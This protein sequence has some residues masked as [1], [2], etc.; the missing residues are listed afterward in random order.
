MSLREQRHRLALPG[1]LTLAGGGTLPEVSVAFE[2]YGTLNAARDNAVLVLHGLTSDQ[3]AAGPAWHDGGKP[4]W[5]DRAIGPGRAIDTDRFYVISVNALGGAGG[6]T[7]P[8]S[9][10]PGTGRRYAMRFPVITIADMVQQQHRLMDA[11]GIGRLHATLG[12]CMGGFQVLEW[13]CLAPE[14]AGRAVIISATPRVS[15]HTIALWSVLRAALMSDPAWNGGEYYDGP[16]PDNGI[17]LLAA[18]GALFWMD[19]YTLAAKFGL[20]TVAGAPARPTLAPQF[21]VE[22]FLQDVRTSAAGKLDPNTMIYLTRA[23]DLFDLTRDRPALADQFARV[24]DPVL[25]VSYKHDWRY[26]P[27]EMAE[28]EDA[29]R[30]AGVVCQHATLPD[31]AGHGA[32]LF[33]F[34]SL[35]PILSAFMA[36]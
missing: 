23:M 32:F 34:D 1:P 8:G 6:G 33:A 29:F 10:E 19:R 17:G 26:P 13:L 3:H 4:G 20:R 36:S 21:A 35:A 27:A 7:G 16:A 22:K 30:A 9:I 14:R 5:W 12:G 31:P 24:R 28:L 11:L 15:T 2:T 25:L 18:I